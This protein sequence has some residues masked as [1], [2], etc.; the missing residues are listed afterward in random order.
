MRVHRY[1]LPL[2]LIAVLLG[3]VQIGKAV[4]YW[5]TSGRAVI[6]LDSLG[7]TDPAGIKGWMTL[8]EVS[9]IYGIPLAE[10]RA[11]LNLPADLPADTPLKD[12]ERTGAGFETSAV[13]DVV[14]AYR[15]ANP[16]S[17]PRGS[18]T[19][20]PKKGGGQGKSR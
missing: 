11:R 19:A 9:E 6:L 17:A 1:V 15:A 3:S 16:E 10:L 8:A 2:V 14:A 5:S 13:R 7:Y 4:D 18:D 20:L 12:L